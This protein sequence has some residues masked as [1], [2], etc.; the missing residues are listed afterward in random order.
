MLRGPNLALSDRNLVEE[1]RPKERHCLF[2]LSEA[3]EVVQDAYVRAFRA[4]GTF[5]QEA[6]LGTWLTRMHDLNRCPTLRPALRKLRRCYF[7]RR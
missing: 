2:S 5:R 1:K 7:E 3:E 4:L 6:A